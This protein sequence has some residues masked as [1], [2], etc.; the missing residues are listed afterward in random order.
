MEKFQVGIIGGGPGGYVAAIRAAQMGAKVALIERDEVGGTCLLRG[1]IPTKAFLATADFLA[2]IRESERFGIEVGQPTLNYAKT[3][4]RKNAIVQK[5]I[6]GVH[7]LLKAH[8]IE[9]VQGEGKLLGDGR[10]GVTLAQ[11][12]AKGE[13]EKI[14]VAT[15][16]TELKPEMFKVDGI[17]VITSREALDL[18]EIPE[19][20]LIIGGGYI[21]CEFASMFNDFGSQVTVVEMLPQLVATEEKEV[22][23]TL[24]SQFKK[25]GITV[26]TNTK[27]VNLDVSD[28]K[29][30]ASLDSGETVTAEKALVAVGRK[31]VT[32]GIGLEQLGVELSENGGIKVNEKLETG[33]T[34]VYAIGDVLGTVMLAHVASTQAKTAVANALGG[35]ETFSYNAI[36]NCIFTR[37]E[38]A[39][40]GMKEGQA[41][42]AGYDVATAKFQF[43]ALGKAMIIEE[44]TGFVKVVADRKSDKVLG[45]SMI[46]PGVTDIIHEMVLAIHAGLS[47]E[48]VAKMI[49]A[50]PTLPESIH[51]AVEGIHKQAI[52]MIS[53]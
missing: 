39:S 21:G 16:S 52:H 23:Q 32:E 2:K 47:V 6:K 28:G 51:E 10:I 27:L 45:V 25:R 46:G 49:H 17:N 20:V 4:E 30:T 48:Q 33:A 40:V 22:S 5:L 37:P 11:G 24:K 12:Q 7:S 9:Y 18:K 41:S 43:S 44:T 13:C 19:S 35:T 34:N 29:V 53:R 31:P 1:C 26:M 36:P 50:H 8:K 15:G 38:I 14:I 3:L 42:E